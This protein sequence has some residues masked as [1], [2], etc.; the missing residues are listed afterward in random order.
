MIDKTPRDNFLYAMVDLFY[1]LKLIGAA[2]Y[3]ITI[4]KPIDDNLL[5]SSL[6]NEA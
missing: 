4:K 3:V 1:E 5:E 6:F 2:T